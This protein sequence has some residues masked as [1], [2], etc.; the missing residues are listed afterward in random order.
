[1]FIITQRRKTTAK[2]NGNME[3]KTL[4]LN[5]VKNVAARASAE[6]GKLL[7]AI[8][9]IAVM[10][11]MWIKVFSGKSTVTKAAASAVAAQQD[12]AQRT[13]SYVP[14][15]IAAGRNDTLKRNVFDRDGFGGKN[16]GAG[17]VAGGGGM[18]RHKA[19]IA[20]IA[21]T[22]KLNAIITGEK[23]AAF[24]D[25]QIATVGSVL[26]LRCDGQLYEF[27]VTKITENTALL[28]WKDFS[29]TV[30]MV[31]PRSAEELQGW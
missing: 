8:V 27:V 24:I 20:K 28:S 6:K 4:N 7:V 1:M 17:D 3:Q 16:S 15:P 2:Q 14:L 25:S 19:N 18:G 21:K 26:N 13:I 9:L 22:I 30:R 10:A 29:I 12:A 5:N 23:P 11:F 31:Q